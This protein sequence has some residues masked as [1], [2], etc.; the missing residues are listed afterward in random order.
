MSLGKIGEDLAVQHYQSLGFKLLERNYIFR[1]G[2]QSGEIDLIV[3]KDKAIVFVEVKTRSNNRFGS[4]AEAVDFFKQR[5]LVRTSKLYLSQHPQYR[6]FSMRIDVAT[7]D[8]DN[9]SQPVII[10][11]NAIEDFD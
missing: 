5:K 8:I 6:D 11:P 2:K 10:I 9:L 7:V 1:R 4:P 3:S